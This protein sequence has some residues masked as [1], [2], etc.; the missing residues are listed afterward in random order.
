MENVNNKI[1]GP[2][3]AINMRFS[4]K[5]SRETYNFSL[6]INIKPK[7]ENGVDMLCS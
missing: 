5:I 2:V 4:R 3:E 7:K 6:V 1:H